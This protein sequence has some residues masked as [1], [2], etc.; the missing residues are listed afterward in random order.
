[1]DVLI[2]DDEMLARQ[3]LARM[4]EK[5][6]G[7]DL[8]AQA[9]SSETALAA[10]CQYDPDIVLLDVQMPGEDGLSVAR[11]IAALEDPPAVIFC[12]AFDQYALD[13]F[14]TEAVGYLLKPVKAEQLLEVLTKAQRVNRVQRAY[15]Q[16]AKL[17]ST[18]SRNHISATTRRGVELIPL[19]D[20]RY[21]I[22]DNKYVTVYHL[23]GEHL[24]DETLKELEEEFGNRLL[25]IHRNA[26]VSMKHIEALERSAQGQYQIRLADTDARP[27]VSR[28]H[29]SELKSL[30]KN[31]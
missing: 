28:R 22:A 18:N 9:D 23:K 2:V 31:L 21:F 8:V 27:T 16:D 3:R 25:R 15:L 24:L 29:A 20:V 17:P 30:L 4:L 19:D 11:R 7:Y 26:L 12:T 10:I 13:A 5:L 14:G 1:M 6:E